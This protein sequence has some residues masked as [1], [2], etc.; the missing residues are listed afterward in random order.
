MTSVFDPWTST[1]TEALQ[2]NEQHQPGAP[3]PLA[4]HQ[5]AQEVLSA[6]A[7]CLAGDGG[8]AVLHCLRLC[9]A[10]ALHVPRW[11]ADAFI[12]RH[13]RVVDAEV[14]TWDEA[15]GR[16]W[17]PHTRLAA[18]RRQRQL[19]NK[20]H[21]AVWRLI[22]EEPD[23]PIARDLF[24]RIGEMRGID[25]CGSTAEDLYYQA[26]RDGAPSVAQVRAAQRA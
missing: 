2:A 17:P 16:P 24:E 18:V 26:L 22:T 14:C 10:N 12:G 21:A 20:V 13:S 6:R 4:Q 7:A 1:A 19:K 8:C 11:L 15:F 25:V 9:L 5:A 23:V 3:E